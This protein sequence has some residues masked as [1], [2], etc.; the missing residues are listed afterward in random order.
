[1]FQIDEQ[2]VSFS[3]TEHREAKA[4]M[5][6]AIDSHSYYRVYSLLLAE[7]LRHAV[8]ATSFDILCDSAGRSSAVQRD[9]WICLIS[10]D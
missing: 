3:Q 4:C 1:M 8:P 7:L 10:S 6:L 2:V 9:A 5:S